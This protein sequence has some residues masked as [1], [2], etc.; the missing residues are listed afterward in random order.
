[1]SRK[2]LIILA[3]WIGHKGDPMSDKLFR[4]L[5]SV[6]LAVLLGG[7]TA[8]W[9]LPAA[10]ADRGYWAIGGE[11]LLILA[12]AGLGL[13]LPYIRPRTNKKARR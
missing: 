4:A 6:E 10:M 1:M 2:R 13:Y 7:S 3:D 11:W 12:A 5:L 8:A 9:A